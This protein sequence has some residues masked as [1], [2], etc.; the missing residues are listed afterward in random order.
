MLT[1]TERVIRHEQ[2]IIIGGLAL[3]CIL[4]WIYVINGAGT[5][6]SVWAMTTAQFPPPTNIYND[7][8][9]WGYSYWLIMLM[10]WWIM[11][12]AMM[13]PSAVPMILLYARV[14]RH[15]QSNNQLDNSIIPTSLFASG[16]LISWLAFSLFVII[17][18]WGLEKSELVHSMMMWSTSIKLS[19]VFLII[20]GIYQFSPLK[21]ACLTHC[22]SPAE[23][24]SKNWRNSRIGAMQMGIKH[25]LYCVGCCWVLMGLL[26][27][28]GIMN[29]LWIVGLAIFILLEKV[30]PFGNEIAKVSGAAMML[31]GISLLFNVT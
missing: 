13:I 24:L 22:R 3:I 8:M 12:I 9:V 5:G 15:A 25:G 27:V 31:V 17:L 20:A 10:M 1:I 21:H 19:A 18:H 14:Y 16:Y 11:M 7:P 4:S 6:M 26:F 23:F 29:L 2:T 28:G 30:T